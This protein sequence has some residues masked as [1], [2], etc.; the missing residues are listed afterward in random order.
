MRLNSF[1][2]RARLSAASAI[3]Q[4]RNLLAKSAAGSVTQQLDLSEL[5]DRILLSAS[6][7]AVMVES[8]PA[9]ESVNIASPLAEESP[10][11][12]A[13]PQTA[14]G[15]SP[16]STSVDSLDQAGQTSGDIVSQ[17]T[18]LAELDETAGSI[19][20]ESTAEQTATEVIFID[21]A[22]EDFEQ[23]IADLESQRDAGRAIDFFVLDSQQDGIDQI[24]ETLQRYSNLDAVHIV[25]H[26]TSGAVK[27][28]A[29]WLR[30]GS[31]DAYAGT[32]AGWGSAIGT[33]G[34]LLFYGCDLASS[35]RGEML[36]ESISALTG[37]DVA[38]STDDTG[39]VIYGGDWDLEYSV[40]SIETDVA[41]S[42]DLQL[43]WSHVMALETV[44]DEFNAGNYSGND[45]STGWTGNWLET[46]EGDGPSSG[47]IQVVG[48][49]LRVWGKSVGGEALTREAD[50]SGATT[51]TL[52][53]E[54]QRDVVENE[55][56]V[57]VSVW[58]GASWTNLITYALS[59]D[60][61]SP[62][63][64]SFDI[65]PYIAADTRIRFLS[66]GGEDSQFIYFDN[67]QIEYETIPAQLAS[68]SEFLVN[69]TTTDFQ[70]TSAEDRGSQQAVSLAAD[71][72][73]V[74]VWSSVNQDGSGWGVY[75][76]RFDSAGAALT[77]EV[78]VAQTTADNQQ[79]ARVASDDVGNFVVTWTSTNQDSTPQSVYARRFDSAGTALANEFRVNT[80]SSGTQKDSS[81]AMDSAGNFVIAWQ[82]NASGDADGIFYRR[83][84][85]DETAIDATDV[86]ANGTNLGAKVDP[87][88][89]IND[90]GQFAVSWANVTN[91]YVRHFDASGVPTHVDLQ[92]DNN[93]SASYAPAIGI[94]ST[95]RTIVV[96]RTDGLSGIEAGVWGRGFD[97]DGTQRLT[98]FEP[99]DA[100][101][102]SDNT[103]PS[104]AMDNAG[105]FVVTYH[106]NDNGDGD[107][108]SVKVR[109]YTADGVS[110]GPASQVN[111][112]TTGNQN[113]ASVALLDVNNFVVVWSGEGD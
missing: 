64:E 25:S 95:G 24:A 101:F 60:D 69:V 113:Q 108:D 71:G 110:L 53:Y 62:V 30:I 11:L 19:L 13:P 17:P 58:E 94:D 99:S 93:L 89:A 15:E 9:A 36:V 35:S 50:L 100:G 88:V 54:Y 81:I 46:G 55:G 73:Y 39:H 4:L 80:T 63:P 23:L 18:S 5:E 103:S 98:Y 85:A 84:N 86:L 51:A 56:S 44:R 45:G 111:V 92:V 70:E 61:A 65:T 7:V 83:F 43:S 49:R 90:A 76:R 106:G 72:S 2:Q 33:D 79:W 22:A 82:G 28:G 20:S 68:S 78:Q 21:E 107:G 26:G 41:F 16:D 10:S 34:D 67:I 105:N 1:H 3:D 109:R 75:A 77:G 6:P 96:Y 29:T 42:F 91:V 57:T 112:S 47:K 52:T 87:D 12:F 104:I 8:A 59:T 38:A 48:N 14:I 27:L 31:L 37:A 97:H 32:I 66:N 40:G 74:V 102:S